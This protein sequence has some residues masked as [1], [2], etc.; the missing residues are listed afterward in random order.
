MHEE[1]TA[2]ERHREVAIK[3]TAWVADEGVAAL[4]AA[5]N[6]ID[7]VLTLDSCQG[8]G[9]EGA[10]VLFRYRNDEVDPASFAAKLGDALATSHCDYLLSAEWRPG[11]SEPLLTLACPPEQV[12]DLARSLSACRKT[13]FSCGTSGTALRS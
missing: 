4:V 3:V 11:E 12:P 9:D 13:A 7:G 8:R 1:R 2:V 5:L 10:Y 6:E